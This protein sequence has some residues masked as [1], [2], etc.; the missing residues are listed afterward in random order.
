VPRVANHSSGDSFIVALILDLGFLA[1]AI[2]RLVLRLLF[3]NAIA[4]SGLDLFLG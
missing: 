2:F 1:L 4:L 3:D